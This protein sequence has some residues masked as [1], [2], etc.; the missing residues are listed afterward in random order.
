M[1]TTTY[2]NYTRVIRHL[3]TRVDLG[4]DGCNPNK[5]KLRGNHFV[6]DF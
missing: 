5:T 1:E 3:S 4:L 6:H 2:I